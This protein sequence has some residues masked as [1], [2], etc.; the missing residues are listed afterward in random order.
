VVDELPLSPDRAFELD[1]RALEAALTP[2]SLV[3]LGSP[4]N[5]T[6]QVFPAS[7]IRRLARAHA[8]C[9][10]LVDEAFGDFVDTFDSLTRDRPANVGVLLSVTKMFAVPGLR[11]GC[12]V[13]AAD[14]VRRAQARQPPWSVNTLAQAVGAAAL[15]DED[16]PAST[17]AFVA[18]E[19]DTLCEGLREL[20]GLTLFAGAANFV[21]CW[22]AISI[23]AECSPPASARWRS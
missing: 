17:R 22:S 15:R 23:G 9:L 11:P 1:P 8:D 14:W 4:N 2:S 20:P 16:Y 12:A 5:P 18:R 13:A 3:I 10:F 19:R 21:L 6:G 7:A